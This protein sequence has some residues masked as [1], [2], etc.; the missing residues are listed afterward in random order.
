MKRIIFRSI[1]LIIFISFI[2][3]TYLTIVGIETKVFNNQ[4]SEEIKKINKNLDI[5]LKKIKI[6]LNPIRFEI[7]AKTISPKL[8]IKEKSIELEKIESQ[9]SLKTLLDKKFSLSDLKI[10]T[11][12][13]E[14]NQLI[15]F[16][17]VM[18]KNPELYILE[19]LVK[20]GYLIA[21][22]KFEFDSSGQIKEN[23]EINGFIEDAYLSFLKDYNISKLNFSFNLK[24]QNYI[25]NDIN[26][27]LNEIPI[28]SEKLQVKAKNDHF[29]IKGVVQSKKTSL[30]DSTINLFSQLFKIKQ[31]IK[32]I[33]F[34]SKNDF[35]LKINNKYKISDFEIISKI[36]LNK[37][38][39]Q[40][41]LTSNYFLP[42]I[43]DEIN[44]S[45][46]EIE[47]NYSQSKFSL[48]SNGNIILQDQ[49]DTISFD[50]NKKKDF[51]EI[52]SLYV[53]KR[54]PLIIDFLNYENDQSLDTLIELK[55]QY[56][57][58][59]Q[60]TINKLS[61]EEGNNKIKIEKLILNNEFK[62]KNF[63]NIFLNYKDKDNQ[64]N[65][66]SI[67]RKNKDYFIQGSLLNANNLIEKIIE[68]NDDKKFDI[69]ENDFKINLEIDQVL[70]DNEHKVKKL[71]GNFELKNNEL[72]NGNLNAFFSN[73]K[74]IKFT[75]NSNQDEKVTTLF[76]DK[77]EPIV[78]RYKFIKGYEDGSLDFY[79]Q[80]KGKLAKSTLKIYDFKL[81]EL[82]ALTKL[83]T[84]A[85]LQGIADILSGEGIRFNEFEMNFENE[86]NLMTI[87]EIYAIGPAI[88]ILM[89]GY[90]EKNKIISLR[91]TLVPATTL[92]KVIGSIPFLG[93]IL[94][95]SKSGEGVF[96]VSFK[97]K[98]PPNNLETTVNPIKTLTPR[99]I[100]RTL[101]KIKKN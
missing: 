91:G 90:V 7:N 41:D 94:V 25:F 60:T 78:K 40:N 75:I 39:I 16:I 70:L 80:K 63:K 53:I 61:L 44:L 33:D 67:I 45:N 56:F 42:K 32:T 11:K 10:S 15:S 6:I 27:S 9:I 1:F 31:N 43:K 20:K 26:L 64:N 99:F 101:E 79:S 36:K 95:G 51:Y 23:F 74:I 72:K 100:T 76:L 58:N 89:D 83:L 24:S 48:K 93:K 35:S 73:N 2:I 86:G 62:V 8:K 88:S 13:I 92:N 14:I 17:R 57:F 21:D 5:E 82:P 18:K 38:I 3:I 12:S 81:K 37:F 66:L 84:L 50:V 68:N 46:Q 29:L 28:A 87:N 30:K 77:A 52:N 59:K 69:F 54:N 65:N 96:G 55:F 19:R 97:I 98:G 47:I 71:N 22:L 85:S 49:K 34:V 4:I